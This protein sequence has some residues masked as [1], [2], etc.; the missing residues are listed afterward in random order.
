MTMDIQKMRLQYEQ[1][2]LHRADLHDDP[3]QQFERWFEEACAAKLLEPNAMALATVGENGMPALRTVLLKYF[4]EDGFIFYTNYESQK[5]KEIAGNS[6]VALLF[7]WAELARQVQ[8][9]G[10]A[11]KVSTAQTLAYFTS[12]PRGSQLGAW[13]SAQSQI[14]SSRGLLRAKWEEM[15]QKFAGGVVEMPAFWGGYRIIPQKFEFWQGQTNR[16]HDRFI[17]LPD[18]NNGWQIHRL[19]P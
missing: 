5:A 7:F 11:E 17:Y 8:I 6:Q 2:G 3:F 14:I 13:A 16:L 12:R 10:R 9:V 18:Q 19:A 15:K 1:V 4:D